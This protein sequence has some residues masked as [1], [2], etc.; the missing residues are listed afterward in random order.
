MPIFRT[1]YSAIIFFSYLFCLAIGQSTTPVTITYPQGQI[2]GFHVDYGTDQTK[3]YYGAADIFLGIPYVQPPVENLRFAK[4][5]NLTNLPGPSPYNA[6]YY[7]LMCPQATQPNRTLMSEDCLYLNV[8]SPNVTS[9]TKYP[10]MLWI[11]GGSLKDGY[12]SQYHYKIESMKWVQNY[13]SYFGGD[14][15][16]VTIFGQS[17]GGCSVSAHTYSPLSRGLFQQAICESGT[18]L[19]CFEGSLGFTNKSFRRASAICNTTQEQWNSKN[20][21]ALKD[22]L[23]NTSWSDF[24]PYDLSS[25]LEAEGWKMSQD[26]YFLP[27]VPRDLA[28]SRPNIPIM[29]GSVLNEWAGFDQSFIAAGIFN[30]TDYGRQLFE[31]YFRL[32]GY[33]LGAQQNPILSILEN[34]YAPPDLADNDH[35]GWFKVDDMIG[36][37]DGFT[38]FIGGDVDLWLANNNTQVYLYE[39]THF[40]EVGAHPYRFPGWN[41]VVHAAEIYFIWLQEDVWELNVLKGAVT[42]ADYRI[43]DWFGTTWTNFAKYGKPTLDDS[44]TPIQKRRENI[45]LEIG[46]D[47]TTMKQNYRQVDQV[48]WNAVIPSLLCG[49]LPPDNSNNIKETESEYT[50]FLRNAGAHFYLPANC[51]PNPPIV[52]STT[53]ATSP[54]PSIVYS[55]NVLLQEMCTANKHAIAALDKIDGVETVAREVEA[56]ATKFTKGYK[57]VN[58]EIVNLHKRIRKLKENG[59]SKQAE[60]SNVKQQIAEIFEE[61]SI[62]P[63]AAAELQNKT[64]LF[65]DA[66]LS[67][68]ASYYAAES[69]KH[70][71]NSLLSEIV[72]LSYGIDKREK[73]EALD[74]IRDGNLIRQIIDEAIPLLPPAEVELCD[75][76]KD[77]RNKCYATVGKKQKNKK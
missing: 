68:Y 24:L 29:L 37:C 44:W 55:T 73:D 14:P 25:S 7:R 41:P 12:A 21:T 30:F 10:V 48:I 23:M 38:G 54:N 67:M 22:C 56:A 40:S 49:E 13:I 61:Q 62:N 70:D 36:T 15:N 18:V 53:Q 20:F 77:I 42:A 35:L 16:K 19:T 58:A 75:G 60:H 45:Y 5:V 11:H 69:S 46:T 72:E 32:F 57:N 33:F 51:N 1:M 59:T 39:Y 17:A 3:L 66:L 71:V 31:Q 52:S 65:K 8:F 34:T 4:P 76:L 2:Q 27:K 28:A 9:T 47:N 26:N 64:Y 63:S 43:L 50:K 74:Y 6:T